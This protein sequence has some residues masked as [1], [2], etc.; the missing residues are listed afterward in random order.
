[1]LKALLRVPQVPA[2]LESYSVTKVLVVND[3]RPGAAAVLTDL[4]DA[5]AIQYASSVYATDTPA[6]QLDFRGRLWR[7][8]L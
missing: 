3:G 8:F 5:A 7:Q 6:A 4:L 2:L 1:M